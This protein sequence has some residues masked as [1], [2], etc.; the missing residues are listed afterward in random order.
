MSQN[1]VFRILEVRGRQQYK[2]ASISFSLDP[3]LCCNFHKTLTKKK[4]K[5]DKKQKNFN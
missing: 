3:Y 5:I 1:A 2:F 4:R